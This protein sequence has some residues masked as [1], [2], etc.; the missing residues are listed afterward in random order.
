MSTT[1]DHV[2]ERRAFDVSRLHIEHR[3]DGA[4]QMVGHAAVFNQLSD[5]LLFFRERIEPGAFSQS[6][7][8]DDVRALMN[9]DSN[10]VLGRNRAGT[11]DLSEDSQGLA[12]RITPPET[13]WARDLMVSMERGDIDQMSFG[14]QVQPGGDHWDGDLDNPVR[15]LTNVRLFDVSVVTFPAY[16][17]TDVSLRRLEFNAAFPQEPEDVDASEPVEGWTP[18]P[19]LRRRLELKR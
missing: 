5:P 8:A 7:H 6:I 1:V 3:D 9:H 16:P 14:F 10:Y 12:I 4:P 18:I 17:Q 13:Q 11:L 19:I 2:T 15:V